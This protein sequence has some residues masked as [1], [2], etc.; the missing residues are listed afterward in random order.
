MLVVSCRP[1]FRL[2][3]ALHGAPAVR[4]EA[5]VIDGRDPEAIDGVR[6]ELLDER[7]LVDRVGGGEPLLLTCKHKGTL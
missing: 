1:T 6:L 4:P 7:A 5:E 3:L 2:G